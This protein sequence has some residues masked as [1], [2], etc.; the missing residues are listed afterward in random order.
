[1][2][3]RILTKFDTE[4]F[5]WDDEKSQFWLGVFLRSASA[6]LSEQKECSTANSMKF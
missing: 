5:N 4:V 3:K 2:L 1:M 6:N